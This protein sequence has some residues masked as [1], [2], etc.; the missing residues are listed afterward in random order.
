MVNI[1][2]TTSRLVFILYLKLDSL[3][4]THKSYY[5]EQNSNKI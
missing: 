1:I 4:L 3:L 2:I 5:I